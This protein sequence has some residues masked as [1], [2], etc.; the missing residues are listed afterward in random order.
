MRTDDDPLG[1]SAPVEDGSLRL[2]ALTEGHREALRDAC[3][4][5]DEIWEIYAVSF[6]PEHFDASFDAL[7]GDRARLPLAIMVNGKLAGM[8]AWIN[9]DP[10]HFT[11]EIG[12]TYLAPVH[13]GTDLNARMKRLL[14]THG[15]VCGLKRIALTVDVRNARSQAA[16]RKVG[17]IFEGVLR[18]HLVTWTVHERDSAVFSVVE[19]DR[20]RLGL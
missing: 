4:Q 6:D 11:A 5:D 14:F 10:H 12:S 1:L 19:R 8:T 18:N 16:C 20:E 2:E 3:A 17:A 7:L 9:P 13:R 15:F